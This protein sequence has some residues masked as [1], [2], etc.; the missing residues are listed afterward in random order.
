MGSTLVNKGELLS[1]EMLFNLTYCTK[2]TIK[3]YKLHTLVSL[4]QVNTKLI[5]HV[6]RLR[7]K[8]VKIFYFP[9]L[10]DCSK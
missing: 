8:N 6:S 1:Y 4:E 9:K 3:K 10:I 5:K 2:L 7:N